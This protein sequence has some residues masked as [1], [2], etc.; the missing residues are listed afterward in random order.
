MSCKWTSGT[1]RSS[2]GPGMTLTAAM[3]AASTVMTAVA[4]LV[5]FASIRKEQGGSRPSRMTWLLLATIA[6]VVAINSWLASAGDTL[7]PLVMNAVG[8]TIVF[9]L[10]L[11]RGS[12][13]WDRM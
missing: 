8:S 5:Y 10:S 9:I 7:A 6:W 3:G 1:V 2:Y 12:G 13:G 4:Y 11:S